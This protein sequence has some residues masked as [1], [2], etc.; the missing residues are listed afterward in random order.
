MQVLEPAT[1]WIPRWASCSGLQH[2]RHGLVN[3]HVRGV[4]VPCRDGPEQGQRAPKASLN[5]RNLIHSSLGQVASASMIAILLTS[6]TRTPGLAQVPG[7][8]DVVELLSIE[9]RGRSVSA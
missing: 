5:L 4:P 1:R 8:V 6:I 3:A 7:P 9:R 2:R